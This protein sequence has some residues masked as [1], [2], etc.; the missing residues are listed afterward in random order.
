MSIPSIVHISI[1][2]AKSKLVRIFKGVE[3]TM[4]TDSL[5]LGLSS[6]LDMLCKL[7]MGVFPLAAFGKRRYG[8][9]A[10]RKV[11][12]SKTLKRIPSA[13]LETPSQ[14]ELL[15]EERSFNE[16]ASKVKPHLPEMEREQRDA[17][18]TE[19]Y[20]MSNAKKVVEWHTATEREDAEENKRRFR[21]FRLWLVGVDKKLSEAMKAMENAVDAAN[22]HPSQ[23]NQDE[24]ETLIVRKTVIAIDRAGKGLG[25]AIEVVRHVQYDLAAGVH[26][27]KRTPAEKKLIPQEPEGLERTNLPLSE[28]TK[29]IDLWFDRQASDVLDKYRQKDGRP[30]RKHAQ[31]IERVFDLPFGVTGSI[32]KELL[33]SRRKKPR[34]LFLKQFPAFGQK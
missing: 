25:R 28:K 16:F 34:Q 5:G 14:E 22:R 23:N 27:R 7:K 20:R 29:K 18:L 2:L 9:K 15:E 13:P 10:K 6:L 4:S 11:W 8:L 17:L 12:R 1:D 33:P 30:I 31:I 24:L 19:L 21:K 32:Q 26:P 3:L